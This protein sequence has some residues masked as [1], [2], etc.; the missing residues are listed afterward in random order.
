M[1]DPTSGPDETHPQGA[2]REPRCP[3]CG[4]P[5]VLEYRPFCSKRCSDIDLSR[6]LN[7]V[8]AV[9]AADDP[10]ADESEAELPPGHGT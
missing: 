7:G 8:Y 6:W 10:D 3:I 1:A 4:R 5:R 2:A 9:P